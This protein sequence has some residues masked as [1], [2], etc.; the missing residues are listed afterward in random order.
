MEAG[1]I[2]NK[3]I[4]MAQEQLIPMCQKINQWGKP[5]S[6]HRKLSLELREKR[7]K[8]QA[9]QEEYKD[10]LR[11]CEKRIR[12]AK[13]QLELSQATAVKDNKKVVL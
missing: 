3:E 6:L 10:V 4:L 8:G 9:I 13:S 12:K 5:V 1:H 2:L 11:S 7:E